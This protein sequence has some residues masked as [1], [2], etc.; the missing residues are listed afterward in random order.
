[1]IEAFAIYKAERVVDLNENDT[2]ENVEFL[3]N[4]KGLQTIKF[5][6]NIIS[7]IN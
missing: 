2:K 1:M 3:G 4:T 5:L 7:P 6:M